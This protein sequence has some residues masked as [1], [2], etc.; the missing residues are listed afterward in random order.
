VHK[1][2]KSSGLVLVRARNPRIAVTSAQYPSPPPGEPVAPLACGSRYDGYALRVSDSAIPGTAADRPPSV[3]GR[4]WERFGHLVREVGKFG[5]V[6]G[7]AFFVDLIV[8][9]VFLD[10]LGHIWAKVVST[11]VAATLAFIGNRFWTWRGRSANKMHREYLLYFV[12]NVLGLFIALAC[13]WISH[14]LL[15]AL[16]PG[17]F[18]TRIADNVSTQIVGTAVGTIFR[19]WAY[20]TLVFTGGPADRDDAVDVASLAAIESESDDLDAR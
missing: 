11:T 2:G 17:I 6:G 3:A 14:D 15:G 7:I 1:T 20:R 18:H 19:F 8:Y 10:S 4:L 5:V 13:A 9:N 16:W 12:F